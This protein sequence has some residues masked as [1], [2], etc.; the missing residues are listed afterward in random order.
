[1]SLAKYERCHKQGL[2]D[3]TS[4]AGEMSIAWL[5]RCH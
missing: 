3:T 1:M 5:E 2:K 4:M